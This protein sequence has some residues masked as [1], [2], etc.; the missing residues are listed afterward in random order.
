MVVLKKHLTQKTRLCRYKAS[1]YL[2]VRNLSKKNMCVYLDKY[3]SGWDE[4]KFKNNLKPRNIWIVKIKN[5]KIGFYDLEVKNNQA[6]LHNL[7][8]VCSYQRKGIGQHLMSQIE[9]RKG[10][11]RINL[12]VFRDSPVVKFYQR[13]G[14]KV[15]KRYPFTYTLMKLISSNQ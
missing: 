1:D 15:F 12:S 2:F 14:Y 6:Y 13:L 3:F 10:I 5:L 4:A 11:K 7:Q 8:L 9:K